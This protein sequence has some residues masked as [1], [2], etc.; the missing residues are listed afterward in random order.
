M[1]ESRELFLNSEAHRRFR[2]RSAIKYLVDNFGSYSHEQDVRL[3]KFID[4]IWRLC[5]RYEGVIE[6]QRKRSYENLM[7]ANATADL[8]LRKE[9]HLKQLVLNHLEEHGC[10]PRELIPCEDLQKG[11]KEVSA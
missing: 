2:V 8:L 3:D 10:D 5:D 6:T 4:R 7:A 9:Q 1:S 11:L